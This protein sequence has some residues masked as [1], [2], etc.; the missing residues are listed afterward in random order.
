MANARLKNIFVP[1]CIYIMSLPC[2]RASSQH[3]MIWSVVV[4]CL[5]QNRL[6][7]SVLSSH[8]FKSENVG[9]VR[10]TAELLKRYASAKG[11]PKDT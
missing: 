5:K 4:C 2:C 6:A 9:S 7:G 8:L 3:E 1:Q 10:L 11:S